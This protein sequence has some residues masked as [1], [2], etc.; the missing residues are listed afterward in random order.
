MSSE[1][2]LPCF[3]AMPF[4]SA[5]RPVYTDVIRPVFEEPSIA[6]EFTCWRADHDALPGSITTQMLDQIRGCA[7]VLADI[8]GFNANIM[9][10]LGF[11]HALEKPAIIISQ[12]PIRSSPF[13]IKDYKQIH[14][15]TD[16]AGLKTVKAQ[17]SRQ[18][19]ALLRSLAPWHIRRLESSDSRQQIEA[20]H[21]LGDHGGTEAIDALAKFLTY[22]KPELAIAVY[23]ALRKLGTR[24]SEHRR[25]VSERLVNSLPDQDKK[26]LLAEL[27]EMYPDEFDEFDL[28]RLL[29]GY[30]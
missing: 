27:V 28:S 26:S 17:L 1:G 8:T 30:E 13:D 14:Y 12:D 16:V 4:S 15:T 22:P 10:E 25:Q 11:A 18:V 5:S 20:A 24:S 3:I 2:K 19:Q 7:F 9:Y 21:W 6:S 23:E 29:K